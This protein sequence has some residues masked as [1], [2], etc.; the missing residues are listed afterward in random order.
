MIKKIKQIKSKSETR[1]S[2]R[3]V[4]F[5]FIRLYIIQIIPNKVSCADA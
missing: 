5:N 3:A 1:L 4:L 2:G